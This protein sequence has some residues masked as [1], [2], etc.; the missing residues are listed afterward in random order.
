MQLLLGVVCGS[1]E[2]EQGVSLFIDKQLE[3]KLH[4]SQH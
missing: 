1:G 4:G 2:N 3:E